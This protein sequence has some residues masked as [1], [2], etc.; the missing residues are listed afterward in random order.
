ME[1]IPFLEQVDLFK[2]W[3]FIIEKHHT[4]A[5]LKTVQEWEE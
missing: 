4:S 2:M 5:L 3:I 1:I